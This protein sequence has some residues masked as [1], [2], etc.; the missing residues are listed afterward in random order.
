MSRN[1]PPQVRKG[2]KP[3]LEK[4]CAIFDAAIECFS[5]EGFEQTSMDTVA[6]IAGVSK[7]TVYNHFPSKDE[8]FSA[9]VQRLKDSC[10]SVSQFVYQ[11]DRTLSDQLSEFGHRVVD[12]HCQKE[13]RRIGGAILPRLL[14]HPELG[15]ALF[16]D[17]KFFDR[18]LTAWIAVAQKKKQL[19]KC[20]AVFAARQFLGLLESFV[21]W[22]QLVKKERN[23][24]QANREKLVNETVAMFLKSYQR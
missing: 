19:S 12:F 6:Q 14:Q 9:M 17:A 22:P 16:G 23:P 3:S 10:Q 21:V 13:S 15:R 20:D 7:R 18:E 2:R 8:L 11:P 5:K 1:D 4:R 24:N